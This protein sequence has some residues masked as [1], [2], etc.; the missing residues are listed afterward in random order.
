MSGL[1]SGLVPLSISTADSDCASLSNVNVLASGFSFDFPGD[2]DGIAIA[3]Y[4]TSGVSVG[5]Y[6]FS[7]VVDDCSIDGICGNSDDVLTSTNGVSVTV[8]SL[9]V[10]TRATTLDT[11]GDGYLDAFDLFWNVAPMSPLSVSDVTV[12]VDSRNATGLS[13]PAALTSSGRLSFADSQFTGW[14]LPRIE[15]R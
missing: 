6:A 7:A 5:T 2:C 3:K 1:P 14:E 12:R 10:L 8:S 4:R 13:Y 9:S 15:V 11:D